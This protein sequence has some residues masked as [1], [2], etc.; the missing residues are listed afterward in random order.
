VLSGADGWTQFGAVPQYSPTAT[1]LRTL[2]LGNAQLQSEQVDVLCELLERGFAPALTDL[3]IG[4]NAFSNSSM[5]AL[6]R[7]RPPRCRVH[8]D[9]MQASACPRDDFVIPEDKQVWQ[10]R[11]FQLR[12]ETAELLDYLPAGCGF[13]AR[14]QGDVD[15]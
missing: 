13:L 3:T 7:V 14:Q 15:R 11:W 6:L 5:N 12:T 10:E 2:A 8:V 4:G 9:R 1:Q